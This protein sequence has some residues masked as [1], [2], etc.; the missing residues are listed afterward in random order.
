MSKKPL[1]SLSD[2]LQ[3]FSPPRPEPPRITGKLVRVTGLTLEVA[4]L[5]APIGARCLVGRGDAP[6]IEAEVVGFESGRLFL[7]PIELVSDLVPGARVW[8]RQQVA[9][10]PAGRALLG[11][12]VDAL[13]RPLDERPLDTAESVTLNPPAHNPLSRKPITDPLDVGVRAINGLLTLGQGQRVGLIAGTGVGKSVLLGMMTRFTEA[14]IVVVGLIGE[15]GRE[16]GDFIRTNLGEQGLAKSVVVAAP[17]DTS[18]LMRLQGALYATAL[19]EYFRDRGYRV[20]LLMDSLTRYAQAQREIA[21]AT[22]EPPVTK[23]YPPS[24]FTR[25]PQLVERAGNAGSSGGTLTAI[26]TLLAEG[27]DTQDPVVDAGR[28]VLDGHIVLSRALADAGHY[29]AIDIAASV[30]R[31]MVDITTPQHQQL[32]RRFKQLYSAYEANRDMISLGM[33]RQGS[34]PL[35]DEA[36]RRRE[37]MNAYLVQGIEER[38]PF[39]HS[40]Q[41]LAE[42]LQ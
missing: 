23:G 38:V 11:R 13:G 24:V 6:P 21:L 41:Q 32:A 10:F 3:R 29:P 36:I 15:R 37:A 42:V 5:Q 19:A 18:P 7:M 30:S 35:V 17:A 27:D 12:V 26:Y 16:V 8:Q 28:G 31:L 1:K 39:D 25:I 20:L 9:H 40:V 22:G 4:G 34:D 2:S 33:Y 14:D